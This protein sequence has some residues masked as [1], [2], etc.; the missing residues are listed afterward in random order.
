MFFLNRLGYSF[1]I[2]LFFTILYFLNCQHARVEFS[3]IL[4]SK[5]IDNQV[6]SKVILKQNYFF[7]GL[8]PRKIEYNESILCPVRGMKEIHQYSSLTDGVL[9]QITFGIYSPRSIEIVCY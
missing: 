7:M 8:L 5:K 9:E 2:C 3:P 6:E 4:Q 1:R